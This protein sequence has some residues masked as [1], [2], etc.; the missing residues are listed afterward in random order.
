MRLAFPSHT[1]GSV[2]R[3]DTRW[4]AHIQTPEGGNECLVAVSGEVLP[5]EPQTWR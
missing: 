1:S 3:K 2:G 5:Q 4:T